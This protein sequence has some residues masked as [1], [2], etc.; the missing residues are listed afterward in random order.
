MTPAELKARRVNLGLSVKALAEVLS[1]SEK[2]ATRWEFGTGAPKDWTWISEVL[3]ALEEYQDELTAQMVETTLDA[4]DNTG[5]AVLITFTT[6][7]DFYRWKPEARDHQWPGRDLYG[8][9]FELHLAA[10]ARAAFTLRTVHGRPTPITPAP[11]AG[12][13]L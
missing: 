2:N 1:I 10:A 5:E 7:A 13:L 12:G 9:P 8:V 3:D 4:W 6:R 11:S